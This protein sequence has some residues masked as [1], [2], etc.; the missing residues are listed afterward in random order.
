MPVRS[1]EQFLFEHA[2]VGSLPIDTL[3]NATLGIDAAHYVSRLLSGRKEQFLDALGGCPAMLLMYLESD[4][5]VFRECGIVP[6]FVFEDAENSESDADASLAQRHKAWNAWTNTL[7]SADSYIDQPPTATEPFRA[8]TTSPALHPSRYMADMLRV[9]ARHGVTALVAP[10]R[11]CSQLAYMRSVNAVDAVYGPTDCLLLAPIDRFIIGMEFPNRD[12]RYVDRTRLLRELDCSMAELVDI[13]MATG[14]AFQ[15]RTLPPLQIYPP[16]KLCDVAVEMALASGTNFYAYQLANE[17][18]PVTAGYVDAYQRGVSALKYTPVM[19]QSGRVDVFTN[20]YAAV[21][22]AAR[23]RHAGKNAKGNAAAPPVTP[24]SPLQ[25]PNDVHEFVAQRLPNEY[26]FY[27]AIGLASG[28]LLDAI[29]SGVYHEREPLDGGAQESYRALVKQSVQEFKNKEL[30]LLTQPINRY[31]QMKQVKQQVWYAPDDTTALLNRTT[32]SIF[33]SLNHL[34]VKCSD[35][36]KEFSISEFVGV[37][38]AA[39]DNLAQSFIVDKVIFPDSVPAAE[40]LNNAFDLLATGMLRAL[41]QLEFFD[42]DFDKR[43]LKPT[44]WGLTLLKFNALGISPEHQEKML[45]LL[46]LLKSGTLALSEEFKPSVLSVLSEHTL[47]TYPQEA[48]QILVL[49]RLLTLFQVEHKAHNHHGPID[50]KTLVFREHLDFVR[51]NMNDMLEAVVVASLTTNE[52]DKLKYDNLE[53]QQR[54]VAHMPFKLALP[55]TAMAMMWEFFLQKYLHNGNARDD[56]MALVSSQFNAHQTIADVD[57]QFDQSR[58]FLQQCQLLLR[59]L[60]DS[61]L[62]KNSEATLCDDAVKFATA[63]LAKE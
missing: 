63:A 35:D 11:A 57:A 7:S 5:R 30:N 34:V 24:A 12:F 37:L 48:Q 3:R 8:G 46:V 25:I 6:V 38:A 56:A 18:D 36:D 39:Q 19:L 44:N 21:D 4:L 43:T 41:V 29:A 16:Y 40:K 60:A 62:V 49:S 28:Q 13:A 59:D 52:F 61:R 31:F 55:S 22:A 26:Y 23:A 33:D 32:P 15:P 51:A 45:L 9:L 42:Y 58:E 50:K 17:V 2:L 1:L 54:I 27:R 14:N 20:D 10:F 53:W 47:R